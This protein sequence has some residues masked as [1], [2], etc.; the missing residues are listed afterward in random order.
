[1]TKMANSNGMD[2]RK[3]N[4]I[5][6][7]VIVPV[8]NQERYVSDTIISIARQKCNFNYEVII[9]DDCSQDNTY[10]ICLD[11]AKANEGN[12]LLFKNERNLGLLGN[13]FKALFPRCRGQFI[14]IC[15]GDDVWNNENKIQQQV[16]YLQHH[17]DCSCVHTGYIKEFEES[18]KREVRNSWESP[19]LNNYGKPMASEVVK[20]TFTSFPV[21][22][23]IMFRSD[24]L[25]NYRQFIEVAI[26]DPFARGEAMILFPIL[27]LS[28][29]FGYLKDSMVSYRVLSSSASHFKD[30][31]IKEKFNLFY[32]FQKLNTIKLL[33]LGTVMKLLFNIKVIK[34]FLF[35]AKKSTNIELK[36]YL[37]Q[38]KNSPTYNLYPGVDI[39]IELGL[40]FKNQNR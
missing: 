16:E 31:K 38:Y 17:L 7:S 14:A 39:L 20:E 2:C 18:G 34:D 23:S 36:D 11:V 9:A 3:D 37:Q 21:A 26:K 30:D 24:V 32:L 27:A 4:K 5:L 15:A 25:H 33:K 12:V 6:V 29:K 28:G 40:C 35:Y 13:I 19:L 8:Y 1:M 22:S 10:G